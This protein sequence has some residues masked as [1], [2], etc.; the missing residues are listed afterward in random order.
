MSKN[1]NNEERKL[2]IRQGFE[3]SRISQDI[4]SGMTPEDQKRI[5]ITPSASEIRFARDFLIKETQKQTYPEEYQALQNNQPISQKSSLIKLNPK[6]KKGLLIM[7]G[8]LGNLYNMPEQMRHPIIL[9]KDS[10]ITELIIL[11]HHQ[12]TAHSGPEL[13][14]RNVR[15]QFWV[16][17]GKRQ[18]RNALRL[19]QHNLCKHPNPTGQNQQIAN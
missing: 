1:S 3:L 9:P 14:L 18:I 15:L 16:T 17:G 13:T 5:H 2:S 8:R 7:Q 10:R 6:L 4:S 11:Q 19:C 12:A